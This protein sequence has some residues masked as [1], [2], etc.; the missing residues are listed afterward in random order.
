[1]PVGLGAPCLLQGGHFRSPVSLLPEGARPGGSRRVGHVSSE[2]PRVFNTASH[3]QPPPPNRGAVNEAP[4]PLESPMGHTCATWAFQ[5]ILHPGVLSPAAGLP[6]WKGWETFL[7]M[8]LTRLDPVGGSGRDGDPAFLAGMF[9]GAGAPRLPGA[10]GNLGK[11]RLRRL[12][13]APPCP[14]RPAR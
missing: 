8:W 11:L 9:Q 2:M 7:G 12:H 4:E 3:A 13:R 6:T 10:S 1:M 14:A 5:N